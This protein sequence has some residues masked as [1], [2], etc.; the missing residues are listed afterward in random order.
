MGSL[1][2]TSALLASQSGYAGPVHAFIAD[3]HNDGPTT[4]TGNRILEIDVENMSLVNSLD[5]PGILGHHADSGFNSKIYG[6]PKGSGFVN[7]IELRKDQN[8]TTSMEKTKEIPLMHKPRSGDAYNDKYKIILMTARNR[9]M[10]SFI[11]VETDEVVG[12]IGENVDCTLTDGSQLL[13]HSDANTIAAA[14]KYQCETG[15]HGGDQVSGHPYWL[16]S[17]IAAIVDRTNKQIS[18]YRIWQ[19]GT[20]IKSAL[21]NHLP[22]RTS[23]HQIVN[24]DRTNLTGSQAADFYAVEEGEHVNGNDYSVGIPHAL[25]KL[26]LRSTGLTLERRM[27]LQ[28]TQKFSKAKSDRILQSCISIYRSTFRQALTG[29]SRERERRYNELFAREGVIR[30]TDQDVNNDF[31]VDCFYAGIP[32][33]HNGDFAPNNKHL[34][35]GMAGGAMSIIDVDRWK[36]ANN[37]DIGIQTGPGHMCFSEKHN[38]GLSTNHG[39][40]SVFGRSMHRSIRYINSERPIGYYWIGLPFTRENIINTAQSH[41]C[42]VDDS[43]DNYYNFF[44]DGGVFYK[45]DMSGVFNNP[46]NGSTALVVDSLYTGGIPIQGSYIDVDDIRSTTPN[47]PFVANNDTAE[48]DGSAITVDVLANDTGTGLVLE[49]VYSSSNSQASNVGGQISY[50]PN[51]GFSGTD[52]VWYAVSSTTANNWEWAALTVTVE[53]TVQPVTLEA[54]KDIASTT[55]GKA[56]TIDLFANDKGTGLRTGWIDRSIGGNVTTIANGTITYTPSATFTG[57]E[58]FWYELIDSS[59]QTTW[60][61]VVITVEKPPKPVNDVTAVDDTA[62]VA[63]GGTVTIDVIANDTGRS[64]EIYEIDSPWMGILSIVNNKLVYTATSNLTGTIDI[65]YGVKDPSWNDSWAKVTMTVTK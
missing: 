30:S 9:P 25:L 23:I 20:Q 65:W 26:K 31:P 39:F 19:E 64:L 43:G 21:L 17:D 32:G 50:T 3:E 15:S 12:T 46:T 60:G 45:I 7:V 2:L 35:V 4:P 11:N 16:T 61:N 22:T 34:Y 24:R 44:A 49:A 41:T 6:V 29:P 53:P 54:N 33:G 57:E 59:G 56:V 38:V 18:T 55:S 48:S 37:I 63:R 52:T 5:V 8:G 36:I 42:Y 1:T 27:D 40:S 14:T 28:R 62:T 10:G 51:S 47:A 58:N 13:S